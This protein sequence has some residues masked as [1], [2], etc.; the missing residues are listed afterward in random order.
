VT[1]GFDLDVEQL[2]RHGGRVAEVSMA[3]AQA[4]A[5][6]RAEPLVGSAFGV[7]CASLGAVVGLFEDAIDRAMRATSDTLEAAADG[8]S[9]MVTAYRAS[10]ERA[11]DALRRLTP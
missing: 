5:S 11:V 2:H 1:S 4:A 6:G 3:V 8:V 9:A 10:D 7:M